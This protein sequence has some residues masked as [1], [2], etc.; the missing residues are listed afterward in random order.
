ME[1]FI[2]FIRGQLCNIYVFVDDDTAGNQLIEK[3]KSVG[4]IKDT[5]YTILKM[6]GLRN[7]ELENIFNPNLYASSIAEKYGIP[8]ENVIFGCSAEKKWTSCIADV[9]RDSGKTCNDNTKRELKK[10]VSEIV[11][12]NKNLSLIEHR[13]ISFDAGCNKLVEYF[14]K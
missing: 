7:S 11:K 2:G 6:K 3:M 10:L 8:V 14:S 12:A 5:E 13:R 1:N 4:T 9:F